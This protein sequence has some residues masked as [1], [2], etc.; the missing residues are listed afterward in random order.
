MNIIYMSDNKELIP[1][2]ILTGFLGSGKTTLLN[3]L[4]SSPELAD[5]AIL[6]N[7]FGEIGLDHLLVKSVDEE[8]VLLESGCV[9]CSVR[10]DFS[11]SLLMLFN[12]REKQELP[13][14]QRVILETTGI[15]EPGP[16]GDRLRTFGHNIESIVTV[17]DAI[18]FPGTDAAKELPLE[19]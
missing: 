6:I 17:V 2:E 5:T 14:F 9:C 7:E 4:L 11:A 12:K 8:I 15:A 3:Q 16:I 10:D 1:I 19:K 13:R 18:N